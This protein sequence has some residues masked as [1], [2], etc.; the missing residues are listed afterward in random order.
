M[1]RGR[2]KS[3]EGKTHCNRCNNWKNWEYFPRFKESIPSYIWCKKCLNSFIDMEEEREEV[4]TAEESARAWEDYAKANGFNP[5]TTVDD[6]N[7]SLWGNYF[8]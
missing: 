6:D 4:P 7:H 3:Y 5:K 2:V 1:K 8:S